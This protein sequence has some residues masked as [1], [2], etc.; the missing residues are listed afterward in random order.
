MKKMNNKNIILVVAAIVVIGIITALIIVNPF[1][2]GIKFKSNKENMN[3]KD[4]ISE[5]DKLGHKYYD[6]IFYPYIE[7][8][9]ELLSLFTDS[10]INIT[11]SDVKNVVEMDEKLVKALDKHKCD[12]EKSKVYIYP[13]APYKAENYKVEVELSCENNK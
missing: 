2:N 13:S 11:L 7:K 6:T 12:L 5:V 8:P 9:E 10:G 4:I 1:K 3:I